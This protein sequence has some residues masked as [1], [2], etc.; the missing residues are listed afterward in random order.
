MKEKWE[1]YYRRIFPD[2]TFKK[3]NGVG[4]FMLYGDYYYNLDEVYEWGKNNGYDCD[5]VSTRIEDDFPSMS[6]EN[7]KDLLKMFYHG[8]K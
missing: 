4:C 5:N 1:A 3:V 8:L 7:S 6:P 2:A